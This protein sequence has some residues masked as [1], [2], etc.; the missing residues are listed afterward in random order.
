[1]RALAAFLKNSLQAEVRLPIG[2]PGGKLHVGVKRKSGRL[3]LTAR[4]RG[5]PLQY[6][7]GRQ[8]S[9]ITTVYVDTAFG[10][11]SAGRTRHKLRVKNYDDPT[12]SWFEVKHR[13]GV[14]V[15]KRRQPVAPD[16]LPSA[17]RQPRGHDFLDEA[18]GDGEPVVKTR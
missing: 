6:V 4:E 16:D 13:R 14:Q 18:P 3:K 5:A 2:L 11:W 12:Q 8:A 10:T 7:P 15:D 1:M 9:D 17:L